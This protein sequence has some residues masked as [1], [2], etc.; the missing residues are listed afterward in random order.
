MM[1]AMIDY[2]PDSSLG[3]AFDPPFSLV[4][5][6]KIVSISSQLIISDTFR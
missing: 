2:Y 6:M 1:M 3:L 4:N 5:S